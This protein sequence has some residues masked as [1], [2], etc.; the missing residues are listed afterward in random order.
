MIAEESTDTASPPLAPPVSPPAEDVKLQGRRWPLIAAIGLAA[1]I[2]VTAVIH[3]MGGRD[4]LITGGIVLAVAVVG[5]VLWRLPHLRRHFARPRGMS[6]RIRTER[7]HQRRILGGHSPGK[8]LGRLGLGSGAGHG[9]RGRA[10]GGLPLAGHGQSGARRGLRS[11]LPAWVPGSARRA[12]RAQARAAAAKAA[13]AAAGKKGA[14]AATGKK[15]AG[16]AARGR[17][18]RKAASGATGTGAKPPPAGTRR[19]RARRKAEA[20]LALPAAGVAAA[21]RRA[22]RRKT[23]KA[24]KVPCERCGK[25]AKSEVT[26]A[27]G[28]NKGTQMLCDGC[29][30]KGTAAAREELGLTDDEPDPERQPGTAIK[31]DETASPPPARGLSMSGIEA[32]TEAIDAHIGGFEPESG[33]DLDHFLAGLPGLYQSMGAALQR[34]ADR[35]G[36]ELPVHPAVRDHIG[37]MAATTAG[38]SEFA[39]E[40]YRIHRTAHAKEME[41]LEN[42]RPGEEIW[43][44]KQ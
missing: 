23:R 18:G 32:V 12:Q 10:G 28:H 6:R 29:W 38:L 1:V 9:R 35:F 30:E 37:E 24:G 20:A 8:G 21:V 25:P 14:P 41:R 44:V 39:D 43:D 3:G 26:W 15:A 19:R 27:D 7:S 33:E 17:A 34:L 42:P 40:A 5:V 13:G 4:A 31:P 36:D 16:P 2:T 22:R 11:R